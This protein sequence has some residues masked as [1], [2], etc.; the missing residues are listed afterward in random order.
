M[1]IDRQMDK[2][3][4]SYIQFQISI[5]PTKFSSCLSFPHI[6]ISLCSKI[7]V[8]KNINPFTYHLFL[9]CKGNNFRIVIIFKKQSSRFVSGSFPRPPLGQDY[10]IDIYYTK[11][12][13]E[14]LPLLVRQNRHTLFY[15]F[16]PVQL[17]NM[18]FRGSPGWP[19][20]LTPPSARV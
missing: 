15:S 20:G 4:S 14:K 7:L 13:W 2:I 6:C 3:I 10:F 9:Q 19:R 11:V 17:K 16:Y 1:Q 12:T 5:H 18:D 8:S